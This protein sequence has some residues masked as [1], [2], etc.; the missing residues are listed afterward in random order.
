MAFPFTTSMGDCCVPFPQA[1][2][3]A[4]APSDPLCTRTPSRPLSVHTNTIE[5][6][7]NLRKFLY[8]DFKKHGYKGYETNYQLPEF[9]PRQ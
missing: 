3:S 8:E 2:P 6:Q 7:I 1:P 5:F 9:E 4:Q